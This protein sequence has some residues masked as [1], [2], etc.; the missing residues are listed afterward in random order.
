MNFKFLLDILN[1]DMKNYRKIFSTALLIIIVIIVFASVAYFYKVKNKDSDWKTYRIEKYGLEFKY[2]KTFKV[3]ENT[4][5]TSVFGEI[6]IKSFEAGASDYLRMTIECSPDWRPYSGPDAYGVTIS[7]STKYI[8]GVQTRFYMFQPETNGWSFVAETFA[9]SNHSETD[10]DSCGLETLRESKDIKT[11]LAIIS[12]IK[13]ING[14][15]YLKN[16]L[17]Q[18]NKKW[19]TG[20]K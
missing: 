7:T 1:C 2:P 3:T 18:A 19:L 20:H 5:P 8:D 13:F 14:F 12:S 15:D 17:Y 4:S 9:E 10:Y 16:Q 6:E 11:D